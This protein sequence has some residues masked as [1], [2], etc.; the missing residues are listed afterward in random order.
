MF[1]VILLHVYTGSLVYFWLHKVSNTKYWK[2][3]LDY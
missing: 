2:L 1:P 3:Y